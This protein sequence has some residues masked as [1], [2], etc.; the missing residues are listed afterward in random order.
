VELLRGWGFPFGRVY[1]RLVQ[2]P[3]LA[4]GPGLRAVATA[5]SRRPAVSRAWLALFALDEHLRA[6]DRGS[7]WLIVGRRPGR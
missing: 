4:A 7:G 1:D 3:V 5:A 6:G 2:R